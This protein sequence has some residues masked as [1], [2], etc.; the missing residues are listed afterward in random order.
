MPPEAA[1]AWAESDA[2]SAGEDWAQVEMTH[3]FVPLSFETIMKN[4]VTISAVS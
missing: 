3:V 4:S 1:V 2:E